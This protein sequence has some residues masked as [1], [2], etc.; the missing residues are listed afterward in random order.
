MEQYYP[1]KNHQFFLLLLHFVLSYLFVKRNVRLLALQESQIKEKRKK[2]K[3]DGSEKAR[4]FAALFMCACQL[5]DIN[6]YCLTRNTAHF[7]VV[8]F[9]F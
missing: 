5:I 3:E 8:Y 2:E 7:T 4:E 1:K 9:F 6:F